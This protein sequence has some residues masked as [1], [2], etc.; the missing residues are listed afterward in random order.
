MGLNRRS[1]MQISRQ[2]DYGVRAMLEVAG[3]EPGGRA[4]TRDV[5][6]RQDIPHVF[7]TK[8]ILQLVRAGLLMS[9]RGAGGGI[10]LARPREEITLRDIVEAVEGPIALNRCVVRAGE[11]P[12]EKT[13]P[14]HPIWMKA[15]ASLMALLEST[16]L[17][18]LVA[19][20]PPQDD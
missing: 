11:C 3:L 19:S 9:Y 6:L 14:V 5:A 2:T 18:D 8:I 13:C 4:R 17:C 20:A 15:Q 12:R 10:G 1:S 7:L 16:R